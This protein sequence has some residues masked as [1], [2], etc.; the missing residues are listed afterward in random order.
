MF[1]KQMETSPE[2]YLYTGDLSA[3][4]ARQ[5]KIEE[6]RSIYSH[7][8]EKMLGT[9]DFGEQSFNISRFAL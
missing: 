8:I 7:E 4:L 9:A 6:A 5:G 2:A 3:Y 1:L